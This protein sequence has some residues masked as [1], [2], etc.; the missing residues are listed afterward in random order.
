MYSEHR[1]RRLLIALASL[2]F[3]LV[4]AANGPQA[5]TRTTNPDRTCCMGFAYDEAHNEVVMFGGRRMGQ[6]ASDQTWTGTWNGASWV[7]TQESPSTTPPARISTRMVYYAYSQQII[8]FGGADAS[9]ALLHDTWM[10]NGSNWSDLTPTV[11]PDARSSPAMAYDG[12]VNP[13]QVVLYGGNGN[14][15]PPLSDTWV[16]TK[17]GNSF[18]W[19]PICGTGILAACGP[20]PRG[21]PGAAYD[22]DAKKVVLFGGQGDASNCSGTNN[23]CKDTWVWNGVN[24]TWQQDCSSCGGLTARMNARM[25]YDTNR[26]VVVMFGGNTCVQ[27]SC[28]TNETWA[29]KL[30]NAHYSWTQ[31]APTQS[32]DARCCVGLAFD[33]ATNVNRTV[34]F[35]GQLARPPNDIEFDDTWLGQKLSASNGL[36]WTCVAGVNNLCPP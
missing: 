25:A 27:S 7:W 5:A 23:L 20:G 14:G 16:G 8:M 11:F 17:S 18:V 31:Q 28:V 35:G 19:T 36:T 32:P 24:S 33:S 9:G 6:G 22:S 2:S 12:S 26:D 4:P 3:I 13:G 34:M 15:T 21:S 29:A 30:I 10:W 1:F